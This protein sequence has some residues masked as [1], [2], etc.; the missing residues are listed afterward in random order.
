MS[1][2]FGIAILKTSLLDQLRLPARRTALLRAVG[3]CANPKGAGPFNAETDLSE[4]A[5]IAILRR[6][7]FEIWTG[8][9]V[10][11]MIEVMHEASPSLPKTEALLIAQERHAGLSLTQYIRNGS[12]GPGTANPTTAG[13]AWRR[14]F[15]VGQ[16]VIPRS[17][18][19]DRAVRDLAS[20]LNA[21]FE[22]VD[23][24]LTGTRG[25]GL[26]GLAWHDAKAEWVLARSLAT[27]PWDAP[28]G[29]QQLNPRSYAKTGKPF[30]ISATK[31]TAF[32]S[33]D[34]LH[35]DVQHRAIALT[36]TSR[37]DTQAGL[38]LLN[39]TPCERFDIHR[40]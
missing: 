17:A 8:F 14:T 23:R 3:M 40:S 34:D 10:A 15:P 16:K 31:S 24:V 18:A 7:G 29:L 37:L 21:P 30:A 28:I 1:L 22:L 33:F 36:L 20:T 12:Y 27:H 5:Q 9:P 11:Y 32:L 35:Y 19:M 25:K 2:T 13:N 38:D 39:G 4:D 26:Y 6:P